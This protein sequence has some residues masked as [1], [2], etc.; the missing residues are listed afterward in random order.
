[1][2]SS[3]FLYIGWSNGLYFHTITLGKALHG[4]ACFSVLCPQGNFP[5]VEATT[6][7]SYLTVM[8]WIMPS[9]TCKIHLF[10]SGRKQRMT[11]VPGARSFP[12][13][14]VLPGPSALIPPT[15]LPGKVDA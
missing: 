3:L 7:T 9:C 2:K 11:F 6:F 4:N 1:M 10:L 12:T 15:M 5:L 8:E 14:A 13:H